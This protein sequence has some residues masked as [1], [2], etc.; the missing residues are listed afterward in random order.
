[1]HDEQVEAEEAPG[2][3]FPVL[4]IDDASSA[5]ATQYFVAQYFVAMS[6]VPYPYLSP[7][8]GTRRLSSI[9]TLQEKGDERRWDKSSGKTYP[10]FLV[11]LV[12]SSIC[13]FTMCVERDRGRVEREEPGYRK[14]SIMIVSQKI[15]T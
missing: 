14:I 3:K 9:D 10:Q 4:K 11:L 5:E 13:R 15:H 7:A 8:N 6:V 2:T 1:M 12:D